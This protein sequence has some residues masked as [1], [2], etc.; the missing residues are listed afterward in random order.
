M[1]NLRDM[2]D[3][4]AAR[5]EVTAVL[6]VGRDGL[7]IASAGR[8]RVDAEAAGA[9]APG[10]LMQVR[11]L[12][13]AA[14]REDASSVVV[15]YRNGVAIVTEVSSELVMVTFVK[16]QASFARLLY[17][18]RHNREQIAALV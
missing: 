8:E 6:V 9:I 5:D 3:A 4:L 14:G 2:L 12:G 1:A 18:L 7:L 17:E 10:V 16:P 13:A 11:E 15:E